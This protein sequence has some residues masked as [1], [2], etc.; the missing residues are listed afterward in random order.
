MRRQSGCRTGNGLRQAFGCIE[1][2]YRAIERNVAKSYLREC[3]EKGLELPPLAAYFF[4]KVMLTG[5]SYLLSAPLA[6]STAQ[7]MPPPSRIF[8]T[9]AAAAPE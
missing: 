6:E 5:L 1:E 2:P 3:D 9:V 4:D 8:P 7:P